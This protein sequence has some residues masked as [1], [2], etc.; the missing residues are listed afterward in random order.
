MNWPTATPIT[1]VE[2]L[3]LTRVLVNSN[4]NW[5]L[6]EKDGRDGVQHSLSRS[7]APPNLRNNPCSKQS[8]YSFLGGPP[9]LHR[10]VDGRG[11]LWS[12]YSTWPH[13]PSRYQDGTSPVVDG[14]YRESRQVSPGTPSSSP[15]MRR[16]GG[17]GHWSHRFPFSSQV[18]YL[19]L[20][21][22]GHDVGIGTLEPGD[23][24]RDTFP[25]VESSVG[26]SNSTTCPSVITLQT[27]CLR[28]V[29]T[30]IMT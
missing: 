15:W 17:T 23:R 5:L 11:T 3:T 13:S 26:H 21:T 1:K 16:V 24:N 7:G 19:D 18:R 20:R 25:L 22:R 30:I 6:D 29:L 10:G 9:T 8:H 14:G 28:R 4:R 12:G 27:V 2:L